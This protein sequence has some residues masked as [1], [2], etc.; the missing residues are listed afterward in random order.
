V[1]VAVTDPEVADPGQPVSVTVQPLTEGA[2]ITGCRAA[3]DGTD[4]ATCR[5]AGGNWTAQLTVPDDAGPGDL[6]LLWDVTDSGGGGGGGTIN[7]RVR[8]AGQPFPAPQVEVW[9]EPKQVRAGGQVTVTPRVFDEDVTITSCDVTYNPGGTMAPCRE[10]PQGWAAD[11]ALP[12]N[13]P[14]GSG[15]LFWRVSYTRAGESGSTDGDVTIPV[16]DPEPTSCGT[17]A[18]RSGRGCSGWPPRSGWP[19]SNGGGAGALRKRATTK[20]FRRGPRSRSSV[21][22]VRPA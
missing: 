5:R 2:T 17:P 12:V 16:L 8:G 15:T 13:A 1:Y 20:A 9:L 7:Y 11:V 14:P 10:N 22:T 18:G 6:P 19:P 21:R 4:G 3:F